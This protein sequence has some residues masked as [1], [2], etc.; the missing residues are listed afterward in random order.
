QA[1]PLADGEVLDAAVLTQLAPAEVDDGARL[2]GAPGMPGQELADAGPV[3]HEADVHAFLAVGRG[4]PGVARQL[5]HLGLGQLAQRKADPR[6]LFRW[7]T[8]EEV[9]LVLVAV[10]R[11]RQ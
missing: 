5:P 4:Q 3:G 2:R 9:A 1:A 6:Q 8:R 7:Y 10:D 11:P